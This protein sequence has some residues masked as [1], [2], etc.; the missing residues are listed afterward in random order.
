MHNDTKFLKEGSTFCIQLTK[1]E[2]LVQ[3]EWVMNYILCLLIRENAKVNAKVNI[4]Q[5]FS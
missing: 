1:Y 2:N 3:K 4:K 5:G